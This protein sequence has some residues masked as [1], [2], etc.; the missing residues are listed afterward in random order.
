MR[1]INKI[2]F[3]GTTILLLAL[4]DLIADEVH[5]SQGIMGILEDQE[6]RDHTVGGNT[7]GNGVS[8]NGKHRPEVLENLGASGLVFRLL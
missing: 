5:L 6:T 4:T 1:D 2:A 8:T 7:A 3:W